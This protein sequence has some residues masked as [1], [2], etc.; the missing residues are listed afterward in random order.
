MIKTGEP[1]AP[2]HFRGFR[3]H[4]IWTQ[5]PGEDLVH[6]VAFPRFLG[7]V[8]PGPYAGPKDGNKPQAT[9]QQPLEHHLRPHPPFGDTLILT[10][11]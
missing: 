11:V 8:S 10:A 3:L 7:E 1:M 6:E 5:Q 4:T 2:L 9:I